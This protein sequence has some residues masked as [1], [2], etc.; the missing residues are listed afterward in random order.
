MTSNKTAGSS[1]GQ[2]YVAA[3]CSQHV[4]GCHP[5]PVNGY[6][7]PGREMPSFVIFLYN[8][9]RFIPRW[10]AAPFGPPTTQPASRRAP[11]MCSRSAS[12]RVTGAGAGAWV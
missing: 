11:R 5:Q 2:F 1:L 7:Y 10:A 8:V 4:N 6:R 12:A 3:P 9:E